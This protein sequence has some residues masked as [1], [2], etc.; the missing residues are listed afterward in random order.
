M[1]IY[2]KDIYNYFLITRA[3]EMEVA[4]VPNTCC[5][6][7]CCN[8]LVIRWLL[9]LSRNVR[10]NYV[11][12]HCNLHQM[13]LRFAS[14]DTAICIKWHCDLHQIGAWFDSKSSVV[15]V[16]LQYIVRGVSSQ[17]VWDCDIMFI[18]CF[19]FFYL[20]M[21]RKVKNRVIMFTKWESFPA[22]LVCS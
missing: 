9:N 20:S 16:K 3:F 5:F 11:E 4:F 2:F 6:S 7:W 1:L 14:N 8:T 19:S 15:W 18:F 21:Y 10:W 22:V 12:K 13:T 17:A